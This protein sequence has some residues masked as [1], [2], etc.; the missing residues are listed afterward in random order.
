MP[1]I[2]VDEVS[3][4]YQSWGTGEDLVLIHG[5]AA[6]MAFWYPSIVL[7]LA[8]NY[9]II[10]YDIRGHGQSAM[11]YKGYTMSF[12]LRDLHT[13]LQHLAVEK[14]H[15]VGHSFGARIALHY[16]LAYPH[17]IASLTVADTQF[18]C[19]QP[20]LRLRDWPY[21]KTWKQQQQALGK[22]LPA[23]D[24]FIT[25][26]LLLKMDKPVMNLNR[27]CTNKPKLSL[28]N[29]DLGTK[30]AARWKQLLETTQSRAELDEG[31]DMTI[32]D[33]QTISA[34][35]LVLFGEF[36]HCLPSAWKLV[37]LLQNCK[38]VVIPEVGHFHPVIKPQLFLQAFHDFMTDVGLG[39]RFV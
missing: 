30:G 31:N 28:K 10:V 23:D 22:T 37:E 32:A 12:M 9:R 21:W 27:E 36:S 13:L 4:H 39:A 16:G 1:E 11:P 19:L 17:Q 26:E 20:K 2:L 6:N 18:R 24:E 8:K 38:I 15:L 25:L 35:T 29:R 14:V 33:L 7:P 3:I 5:L 34:P